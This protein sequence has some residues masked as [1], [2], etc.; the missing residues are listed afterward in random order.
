VVDAVGSQVTAAISVARKAGRII[1]FGEDHQAECTIR[2]RDI[3]GQE[4]RVLGSFIGLH[5]FPQAV[6]MLETN[7]VTLCDLITHRLSLEELPVGI[8]ELAAGKGAKGVCFP[9][10]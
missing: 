3:Q 4:V 1:V 2:P 8:A 5:L 10:R 7:A 6:K 9:W